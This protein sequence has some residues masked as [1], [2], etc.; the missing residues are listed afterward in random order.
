MNKLNEHETFRHSRPIRVQYKIVKHR[1]L[2]KSRALYRE[3]DAIWDSDACNTF[4][5]AFLHYLDKVLELGHLVGL[6]LDERGP[7]ELAAAEADVGLHVG[8][9]GCQNV[10]NH[11]HRHPLAR[12]LLPNPQSPSDGGPEEGGRREWDDW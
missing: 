1:A 5:A 12:H 10:S 8:Q 7:V 3:Y 4:F 2:V 6:L 11:L 9:L